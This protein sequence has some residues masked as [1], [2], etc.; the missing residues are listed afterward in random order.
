MQVNEIPGQDRKTQ[1]PVQI[2]LPRAGL[3]VMMEGKREQGVSFLA[4]EWAGTRSGGPNLDPFAPTAAHTP[5]PACS[6]SSSVDKHH[7]FYL[8]E[9]KPPDTWLPINLQSGM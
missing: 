4:Q 2:L 5:P 6:S 8:N 3:G 7:P 9:W 1:T